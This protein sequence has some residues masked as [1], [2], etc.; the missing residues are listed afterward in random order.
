NRPMWKYRQMNGRKWAYRLVR[1]APGASKMKDFPANSE[2]KIFAANTYI[3]RVTTFLARY[4]TF[5][6]PLPANLKEHD[7]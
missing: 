4:A 2:I 7:F 1:I 5:K 6:I 3:F